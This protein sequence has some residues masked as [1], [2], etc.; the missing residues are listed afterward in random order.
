M[1]LIQKNRNEKIYLEKADF[2]FIGLPDETKHKFKI[3]D[4]YG[5][6]NFNEDL[7][8]IN[9]IRE[10]YYEP[11]T[12]YHVVVHFKIVYTINKDEE[13]ELNESN[14]EQELEERKDSLLSSVLERASLLIANI[15]NADDELNVIT[16]PLLKKVEDQ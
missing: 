10:V 16:P 11:E 5:I 12:L 7:V 3:H 14:L 4:S 15:T 8:S 13:K 6:D 1:G 9:F 2:E